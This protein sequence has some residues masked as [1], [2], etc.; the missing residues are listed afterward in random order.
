[1]GL[2]SC[3]EKLD[4]NPPRKPTVQPGYA[5]E[6]TAD[7]NCQVLNQ[8]VESQLITYLKN[9]Q[10]MAS[11]YQAQSN[12]CLFQLLVPKSTPVQPLIIEL[13]LEFVTQRADAR[14]RTSSHV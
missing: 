2:D 5:F 12:K 7:R 4:H 9:T 1:M 6:D 13:G 8:V 3:R 10:T 14:N 11:L